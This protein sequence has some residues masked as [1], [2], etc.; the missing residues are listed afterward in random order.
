M[1]V[2]TTYTDY[3]FLILCLTIGAASK[4]FL[5]IFPGIPL[6]FT[7]FLL[8]IGLVLG[9]LTRPKEDASNEGHGH[10][11]AGHPQTESHHDTG[12]HAEPSN[13]TGHGSH[14]PEG[15]AGTAQ[16]SPVILKFINDFKAHL[17]SRNPSDPKLLQTDT[18]HMQALRN[19]LDEKDAWD[20][21]ESTYPGLQAAYA[22]IPAPG[23]PVTAVTPPPQ[24]E[25][26]PVTHT[27]HAPSAEGHGQSHDHHAH[28]HPDNTHS[29][30]HGGHEEKG[31]FAKIIE[32]IIG[33]IHWGAQMDP[34]LILYVFLP[35]LI[36]EAAFA[37]DMHTFKKSVENAFW[38]A[39]PGIITATLMTGGLLWLCVQAPNLGLEAWKNF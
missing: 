22:A 12:H 20:F 14:G 9:A 30:S 18:E 6:P 19:L 16:I 17:Q 25:P 24:P 23:A 7:V 2:S 31:V 11:H 5:K 8:I 33:A 21:Y 1:A 15:S 26:T 35:V 39:G 13:D 36:F 10:G 3:F 37:L 32:Y 28:A 34:H 27:S 38:M 29:A 4:H